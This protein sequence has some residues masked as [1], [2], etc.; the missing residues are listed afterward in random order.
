MSSYLERAIR[1][2]QIISL[3][4]RGMDYSAIAKKFNLTK[5]RVQ[6]IAWKNN[7][8]KKDKNILKQQTIIKEVLECIEKNTP[9]NTLYSKY[10]KGEI[11]YTFHKILKR[12]ASSIQC[13]MKKQRIIKLHK[14]RVS[15]LDIAEQVGMGYQYVD[16]ILCI[17]G[18]RPSRKLVEDR[19]MI[20]LRTYYTSDK[21]KRQIEKEFGVS[22]NTIYYLQNSKNFKDNEELNTLRKLYKK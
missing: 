19:G 17:A 7:I 10:K 13:E 3:I 15:I 2:S 16:K 1:D 21:P 9:F 12:S 8:T 4:E 5:V 6:Q 18:L 11:C 22:R 14:E 20:I